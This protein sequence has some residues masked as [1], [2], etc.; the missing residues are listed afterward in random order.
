MFNMRIIVWITGRTARNN[1]I[2]GNHIGTDA[3]GTFASGYVSGGN[4]V[5][6]EAGASYNHIGTPDIDG[7]NIISGNANNGVRTWH[8]ESDFNEIQ[9]N[10]IG[11]SPAGS[12]LRNNAH[13]VDV[14]AG[15]SYTLIGGPE[16]NDRNVISANLG[17]GIEIS[18]APQ[19]K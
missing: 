10:L 5:Y 17:E 12:P 15:S 2:V 3:T 9:N 4:A 19:R 7:R 16:P 11:L 18:H 14:N 13:G 1:F 8:D 6:V